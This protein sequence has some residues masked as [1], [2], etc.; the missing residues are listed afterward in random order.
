M[1]PIVAV[2]LSH[3]WRIFAEAFITM[4]SNFCSSLV[5]NKKGKQIKIV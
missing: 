3:V 1:Q 2:T 5:R 4:S